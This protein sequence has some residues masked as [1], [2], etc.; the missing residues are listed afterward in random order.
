MGAVPGGTA[1][2]EYYMEYYAAGCT[3]VPSVY[4]T[5]TAVFD[6]QVCVQQQRGT[7]DVKINKTTTQ[8]N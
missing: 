4:R 2:L 7:Q 1:V 3:R 5:S 6:V 8:Q